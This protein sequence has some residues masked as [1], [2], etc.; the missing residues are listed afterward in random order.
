MNS[1]KKRIIYLIGF[2]LLAI[3][4]LNLLTQKGP[5]DLPGNFMEIAQVRN[6]NNTGPVF[7]R[8]AVS[9][10][11]TLWREMEQYGN[12]M[13][14]TKLGVTEVFFFLDTSDLPRAMSLGEN[15]FE[16]VFRSACIAKYQKNGSGQVELI[17]YP[18]RI[19]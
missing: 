16:A 11:D 15:P 18:F 8:Y 7:R 3:F 2:A 12:F 4:A 9:V 1:S 6:E 19:N 10:S 5:S 17:K 13:P 14:H